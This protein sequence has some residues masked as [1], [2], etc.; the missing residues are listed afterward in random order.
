MSRKNKKKITALFLVVLAFCGVV[1]PESAKADGW[2]D[3]YGK[4]DWESEQAHL[5]NYAVYLQNKPEMIGY[6]AHIWTDKSDFDEMQRRAKRAKQFLITKFKI[7]KNR[8]V[9][10]N[11]GSRNESQTVLQPVR[12]GMKAPEFN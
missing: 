10:V 11:G 1:S 9:I 4:I 5:S 8:I 2:Y 3:S 7:N 12:K 6:V